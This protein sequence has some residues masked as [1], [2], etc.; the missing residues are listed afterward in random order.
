[1]NKRNKNMKKILPIGI[2]IGIAFSFSCA[3]FS[4]PL[5]R[6]KLKR[7]ESGARLLSTEEPAAAPSS[8]Q[9]SGQIIGPDL[10]KKLDDSNL[11][12]IIKVDMLFRTPSIDRSTYAGFEGGF[13]IG[14]DNEVTNIEFGTSAVDLLEKMENAPDTA[15]QD[16]LLAKA[17]NLQTA[18]NKEAHLTFYSR[19]LAELNE[20]LKILGVDFAGGIANDHHLYIGSLQG[21]FSR[22]DLAIMKTMSSDYIQS[23]SLHRE[24][25]PLTSADVIYTNIRAN[26]AHANHPISPSDGTGVRIFMS[27]H[28]DR[29]PVKSSTSYEG[30]DISGRSGPPIIV[31]DFEVPYDNDFHSEDVASYLLTTAPGAQIICSKKKNNRWKKHHA[32]ILNYSWAV[33][34]P[35]TSAVS[36]A[37]RLIFNDKLLIFA[38]AGNGSVASEVLSPSKARNV[39]SV[40]H[41]TISSSD[42]FSNSG[43]PATEAVK[44]EIVAPGSHTSWT[45][46]LAAGLAASYLSFVKRYINSSFDRQPAA[47]KAAMLAMSAKNITDQGMTNDYEKDGVGSIQWNPYG[48]LKWKNHTNVET[49]FEELDP[50]NSTPADGVWKPFTTEDIKAYANHNRIRIAI[51]WLNNE[52]CI[53]PN[54][55][56]KLCI[57]L[58]LRVTKVNG[59]SEMDID[60]STS[61]FDSWEMI[62]FNI[63]DT[64]AG[65][66]KVYLRANRFGCLE[67]REEIINGMIKVTCVSRPRLDLGY[68]MAYIYE[69]GNTAGTSTTDPS[70][71]I[72]LAQGSGASATD[73]YLIKNYAQLAKIGS[74][75][76]LS[77]D[78]HYVLANDIDASSSWSDGAS[79]CT[80]YYDGQTDLNSDSCT[81]WEPLGSD[82]KPFTGNFDGRGYTISNLY[83]HRP[84][85]DYVGFF[86]FVGNGAAIQNVGLTNVKITGDGNVG[87]LAGNNNGTIQ[88]TYA[89]GNV[90]GSTGRDSSVGGLVGNNAGMI[91][92]T[93]TVTNVD[94]GSGSDNSVGGLVGSNSNAGT[95]QNTYAMGDVNGSTGSGNSVG[96]L[97][98]NNTGTVQN[99][100]YPSNSP[101]NAI[102]VNKTLEELR[103]LTDT[104]TGWNENSWD[105]GI[106]GTHYPTLRSYKKNTETPSIQIQGDILCGQPGAMDLPPSRVL[107]ERD[108][109]DDDNDG[110]I[111]IR[112]PEEL[113]N[114][115][116]NLGGTSYKTSNSAV[117][118]TTGCGGQTTGMNT[119]HGYE[120]VNDITLTSKWKPI[121]GML[122]PSLTN[123]IDCTEAG[124]SWESYPYNQ[125]RTS[126]TGNFNGNG[127]T[128]NGLTINTINTRV[129]FFAILSGTVKNLNFR[130][131][132]GNRVTSKNASEN[133]NARN[134]IGVVAGRIESNGILFSCAQGGGSSSSNTEEPAVPLCEQGGGSSGSNTEEP[135]C[136]P[137][138]KDLSKVKI[139]PALLEE[140]KEKGAN[141]PIKVHILLRAPIIDKSGDFSYGVSVSIG[142]GGVTNAEVWTDSEELLAV[143]EQISDIREKIRLV[144]EANNAQNERHRVAQAAAYEEKFLLLKERMKQ[145]GVDL[146]QGITNDY[147][148]SIGSI[149]G[150]LSSQDIELIQKYGADIVR[151]I[152]KDSPAVPA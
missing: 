11:E 90:N 69:N 83:I 14:V 37:N 129:G 134:Q 72:P 71:S 77:M 9:P 52:D 117:G 15:A 97:A 118:I 96:G 138:S 143:L 44:P 108:D 80:P 56:N 50:N 131:R 10:E 5:G 46:P 60:M 63:N 128:I 92:N 47:L 58:D 26:F 23:I 145:Y 152:G 106:S 18:R 146:D 20:R 111:E 75:S 102:G 70:E 84:S 22:Q 104:N 76:T 103:A 120:L 73:P 4:E 42:G 113:N 3:N 98:G 24:G 91:Q 107:C 74:S 38:A 142:P 119:C 49:Y 29:C 66:Y 41:F 62:D 101:Q 35:G 32:S 89:T 21:E 17:M 8:S 79:G 61:R 100:Y 139:Y 16:A 116:Y 150:E 57:D 7:I 149:T 110:L 86:S 133:Y 124:A 12:E 67:E 78:K 55:A 122:V 115:R 51:S 105:F 95:I 54:D 88:N 130:F 1:M 59:N 141:D 64:G 125:C 48:T 127:K 93:Y 25:V 6:A 123:W 85:E 132:R 82:T 151:S 27:E 136:H 34:S 40:G 43:D 65:D 126:F 147:S 30:R 2:F 144:E 99:S 39:L 36:N 53:V 114:I 109:I 13:S 31:H 112:T 148:L 137:D 94:G 81:G 140:M 135:A 33:N 87:S 28:Y 19:R 45:S 121:A 68:R